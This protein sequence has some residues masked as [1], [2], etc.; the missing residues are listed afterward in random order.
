MYPQRPSLPPL[1]FL[2]PPPH[3]HHSPPPPPHFHHS[4][5]PPP[6]FHHSPIPRGNFHVPTQIIRQQQYQYHLQRLQ[7][8]QRRTSHHGNDLRYRQPRTTSF[9]KKYVSGVGDGLK[10]PQSIRDPRQPPFSLMRGFK[11]ATTWYAIKKDTYI[12]THTHK[13]P[14]I[15]T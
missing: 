8:Q 1:Y 10:S 15:D 3:F 13:K 12:H 11:K 5:P 14:I 7:Q 6:H 2:P 9:Q 4:P